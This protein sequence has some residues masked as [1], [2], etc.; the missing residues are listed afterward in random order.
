[1]FDIDPQILRNH[2]E[3]S[4]AFADFVRFAR[5]HP[6]CLQPISAQGHA[7]VPE[8]FQSYPYPVQSWPAFIS[9]PKLEELR[10]VTVGL[11]RLLKSVPQRFFNNDPGQ[12]AEFLGYSV[13]L[14]RYML[15]DPNGLELAISRGDFIDTEHGPQCVEYNFSSGLG[16]WQLDGLQGVWLQAAWFQEFLQTAGFE[17]RYRSPIFE[18]FRYATQVAILRGLGS[19]G[20]LNMA[21][22][23]PPADGCTAEEI[24][25]RRSVIAHADRIYQE[26]LKQEGAGLQGGLVSATED[27]L[28]A[29]PE[30]VFVQ[31]K[32]IHVLF[33]YG[34]DLR[35]RD[36]THLFRQGKVQDFNGPAY[37]LINDKRLLALL[38]HWSD[39]DLFSTAERDLIQRSIPWTRVVQDDFTDFRG[40]RKFLPDVLEDCR[41][42]LVIKKGSSSRGLDIYIGSRTPADEWQEACDR[43]LEDGSWIVQERIQPKPLLFVADGK[44]TAHDVVWGHF[45]FGDRYAGTFLRMIP[46][47]KVGVVNSARGAR[48]AMLLEVSDPQ[49]D[50]SRPESG[51]RGVKL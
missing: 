21:L 32:R 39:S 11:C 29:L 22:L 48:E 35:R 8:Y 19:E 23:I 49:P 26:Y 33:E 40:E 16:G 51:S 5:S 37:L 45:V 25:A 47:G 31:G 28:E 9:G 20:R 3:L 27:E 6:E 36:I 44:P 38:S 41:E 15:Q 7:A 10:R 30:G 18:L 4:P 42:Q 24:E 17:V 46:M 14:V 34:I 2:E 50:G 43:A 1:M 12:I 13:E